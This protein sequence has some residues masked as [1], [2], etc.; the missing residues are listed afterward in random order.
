MTSKRVYGR[1]KIAAAAAVLDH[2]ANVLEDASTACRNADKHDIDG[3]VESVKEKLATVTIETRDPADVEREGVNPKTESREK[4]Y[5]TKDDVASGAAQAPE[6]K[7][8]V[9]TAVTVVIPTHRPF[10]KS[11]KKKRSD[12]KK[13]VSSGIGYVED[14]V[15]QSYAKPILEEARSPLAAKG[16]QQFWHWARGAGDHFTV[17][18]IAEGSYGEVYQLHLCEDLPERGISKSKLSKLKAYDDG[19]FKIVPLRAQKGAGSKKFTS[20][21]EIVAEVQLLKLLDPVPGFARFR[22]VHVVQGRFP[23]AYQEAWDKYRETHDDCYNPDPRLKRSYLDTQLWAI[24]EM[25]NAGCELERF[26]RLSISQIYDIFWGVALGL[27]RAEQLYGFEHRDLH[28]GNICIKRKRVESCPDS[29]ARGTPDDRDHAPTGFGLS[30]IETTIIDYSLSRAEYQSEQN[31]NEFIIAWSDLDKKQIFDSI[32]RDEEEKLLRDT[33]RRM[34]SHIY[35]NNLLDEAQPPKVPL[36]W[37]SYNPGT[38]LIWLSFVLT[39]LLRRYKAHGTRASRQPLGERDT[40]RQVAPKA[41]KLPKESK[42]THSLS[43][44]NELASSLPD[45]QIEQELL[46]RL[47]TVL[48]LLDTEAEDNGLTCAGDLVATAIGLHWLTEADFLC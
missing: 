27:A 17:E 19:V 37:Q 2:E 20:I 14:P 30:G 24:L 48:G 3:L 28:L 33:Y 39:I 34:R 16:V 45:K 9:S 22:E 38:N 29:L 1:R 36:Q 41:K 13:A 32:G 43:P 40:N 10:S 42:G 21:E 4:T 15:V 46:E 47:E 26:T 31:A 11:A 12:E 35:Q 44:S 7:R 5:R 6:T 8:N 23:A 18:K 25:D